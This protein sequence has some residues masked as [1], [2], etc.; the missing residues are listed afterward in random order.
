MILCRTLGPVELSI[1]GSPAP[2]ELLWRKPFALL[3]YLARSPALTRNRE[4]LVGLLWSDSP[5][6]AARHSL[7]EALRVLRRGLGDSALSTTA[8]QVRL[9]AGAVT[10]D[11]ELLDQRMEAK[12]WA[13]AEGLIAGEFLEGFAL[14]DAQEFQ[15]WL[16]A[17]RLAWTRRASEALTQRAQEL[18]AT[19]TI[20]AAIDVADR[21]LGLDRF[22]EPLLRVLLRALALDDNRAAALQRFD[23]FQKSMTEE[24]SAAPEPETRELV[25]RIRRGSH[26]PR[27]ITAEGEAVPPL[28]GRGAQMQLILGEW[29]AS[30]SRR[31]AALVMIQGESGIGKTHL[32]DEMRSHFELDGAAVLAV[33]AVDSEQQQAES[34]ILGLARGGLLTLKGI[35][36]A[37]P[38]ALA[39]FAAADPQWRE[40]YGHITAKPLPI[41]RA[42][43]EVLQVG[44]EEQPAVLV[45]DDA[46]WADPESL[47][48]LDLVLRDLARCPL[49]VIVAATAEPAR[50]ELDALHSSIGGDIP[51][52]SVALNTLTSTDLRTL[53]RWWFPTYT[54][55]ALERVSRRIATDSAGI[56]L[57][58]AE[59]FRAVAAGLDLAGT[60]QTWPSPFRTLDHSLPTD[61]P[62]A[63]TAA[64][65]V[66]FRR[67]SQPAQQVTG[68]ASVLDGRFDA[69]LMGRL[70]DQPA[71][72]L[73]PALDELEWSRW[74]VSDA[75]G[76]TFAARLM[77]DVVAQ[78]MLT[79]GQ[80]RRIREKINEGLP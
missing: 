75:R 7:N 18:L 41:A 6:G 48:A 11:T 59:L 27:P 34:V 53:A 52:A 40:T 23:A 68:Y 60:A 4:H 79:E 20:G 67:L 66:R 49:L 47:E 21:G 43:V 74:L 15:H 37:R 26:R 19:G 25:E 46:Q 29:E 24:L 10:L 45:V 14:P 62:G 58:A 61:L 38:D 56:P 28:V 78:D 8:Q 73:V 12:D 2:A 70:L 54:D 39:S 55:T 65:R 36:A 9:T 44:L 76:Y 51:G 64:I 69:E 57:L 17:E 13:G 80:R 1:H 71:S 33:R 16:D 32:L 35:R 5:E 77:K 3:V 63:V 30:R 22:A 31:R 50:A 72:A 42:L